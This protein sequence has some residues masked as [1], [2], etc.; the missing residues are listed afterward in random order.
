M[1]VTAML[2]PTLLTSC[3]IVGDQ[4]AKFERAHPSKRM[5]ADKRKY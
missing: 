1:S 5:R 3:R 4:T 2:L